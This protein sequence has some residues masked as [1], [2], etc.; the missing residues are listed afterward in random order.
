MYFGMG[1]EI[2]WLREAQ[3]PGCGMRQKSFGQLSNDGMIA[4]Y[5]VV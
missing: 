4:A 3:F 1:W 5:G 2:S